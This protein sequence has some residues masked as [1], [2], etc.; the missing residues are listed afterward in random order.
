MEEMSL[1]LKKCVVPNSFSMKI[2]NELKEI[3]VMHSA[4]EDMI[5]SLFNS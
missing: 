5:T 3:M 4:S 2:F 1:Q